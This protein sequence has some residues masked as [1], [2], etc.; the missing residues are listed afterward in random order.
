MHDFVPHPWLVTGHLQTLGTR[1][2]QPAALAGERLRVDLGNGD[3]LVALVNEPPSATPGG[4]VLVLVHGMTGSSSSGYMIRIARAAL[5]RGAVVVRMNMRNCGEGEG[6]SRLPYHSG[7]SDDLR[8]LLGAVAMR[9]PGR[10]IGVIGYSLGGNVT[11]KM[12]GELPEHPVAGLQ[13]VATVAAP[14]DLAAAADALTEP[15][16]WLYDQYFVRGLVAGAELISRAH[17]DVPAP[18]FP[19]RMTVRR[20]DDMYTAPRSGFRGAAD[21]YARCS[22]GPLLARIPVPTLLMTAADDPFVPM[23]SYENATLSPHVV[24]LYTRR[25]GHCAYIGRRDGKTVFWAEER[26]LDFVLAR[27]T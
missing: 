26:A 1:L 19:R 2:F 13:V 8:A 17:A 20:F 10:P 22:S 21:Y 4:P 6:C 24:P 12:A 11:L 15:R 23:G 25:G 27:L 16:N 14:I 3:A 9:Y 18:A 5:G 7:R